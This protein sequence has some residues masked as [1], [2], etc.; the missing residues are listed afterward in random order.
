VLLARWHIKLAVPYVALV[1]A[2]GEAGCKISQVALPDRL[3]AQR[4]K[5]V[6]AGR[7][8]VHKDEFH[9]R[10]PGEVACRG[11]ARIVEAALSTIAVRKTGMLIAAANPIIVSTNSSMAE[12]PSLQAIRGSVRL[13]RTAAVALMLF[14]PA[15]F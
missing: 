14:L 12:P 2:I 11:D 10:P 15:V 13:A 7:P 1:I 6:R 4:A 3:T 5:G 8:A 9:V